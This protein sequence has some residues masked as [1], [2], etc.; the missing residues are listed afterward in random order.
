MVIG[1]ACLTVLTKVWLD[2]T[3]GAARPSFGSSGGRPSPRKGSDGSGA[4]RLLCDSVRLGSALS[5]AYEN[6][7]YT[8]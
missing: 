2:G 8:L 3:G 7:R 6:A 5:R 4:T 1:Y